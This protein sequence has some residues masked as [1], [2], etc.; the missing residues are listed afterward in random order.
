MRT[1]HPAVL[2]AGLAGLLIVSA[3]P[4]TADRLPI[5]A[6][7]DRITIAGQ[8]GRSVCTLGWT[9][10]AN[11]GRVY[12]LTGGHCATGETVRV[13]NSGAHGR[14]ILHD[15]DPDKPGSADYALIDFGQAAINYNY[16]G[17]DRAVMSQQ[18]AVDSGEAICRTGVSTGT[19]CGTVYGR[20]GDQQ[21]LVDEM[22]SSA[23]GDS[24]GPVWRDAGPGE[25]EGLGLWLGRHTTE[26]GREY[27]RF[28]TIRQAFEQL[29]VL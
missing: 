24:G 16:L 20:Y 13:T 3:A 26:Y 14:F 17:N 18:N 29:G 12:G 1:S 6:P 15:H 21:Y 4:A 5:V 23:P 2:A 27:G 19:H 28:V 10:T 9:Y 7:G 22:T 11:N 25:V 8:D